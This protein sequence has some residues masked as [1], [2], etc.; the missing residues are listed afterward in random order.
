[1]FMY[2][3]IE[4]SMHMYK[5]TPFCKSCSL[6][7]YCGGGP[8][9]RRTDWLI[10]LMSFRWVCVSSV[11]R[12]PFRCMCVSS[13][14]QIPLDNGICLRVS[15]SQQEPTVISIWNGVAVARSQHLTTILVYYNR[16]PFL[17]A[18]QQSHRLKNRQ[19]IL[20]AFHLSILCARSNERLV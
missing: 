14:A 6:G 17:F 18:N 2:V 13:V 4:R 20:P 1:M 7:R 19:E 3:Y 11:A 12:I 9:G 16:L 5:L 15:Y 8:E 10:L